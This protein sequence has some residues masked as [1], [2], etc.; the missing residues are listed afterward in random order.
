MCYQTLAPWRANQVS[1]CCGTKEN[2]AVYEKQPA[3]SN[4]IRL[5]PGTGDCVTADPFT[6]G[7][8]IHHDMLGNVVNYLLPPSGLE[9]LQGIVGCCCS[10][11]FSSPR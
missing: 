4:L 8:G 1:D 11:F 2:K 6:E 9:L 7:C 10:C 3:V 5:P